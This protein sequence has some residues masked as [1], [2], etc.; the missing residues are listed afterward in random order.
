MPLNPKIVAQ[1]WI[2]NWSD[3]TSKHEKEMASWVNDV[4]YMAM[5]RDSDYSFQLIEAI[6]ELNSEQKFDEV[7]AAGPVE[8]LLAHH[9]P[10]II[11]R[12]EEK[13][14]KDPSFAHVLGGVW[15]NSMTESI[16]ERVKIVRDTAK[17]VDS[18]S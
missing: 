2:A 7:F 4:F 14:R 8:D 13:A 18:A 15:Q 12:I 16:W 10:E 9:G 6:H 5:E 3:S 1:Y 17:W 11:E